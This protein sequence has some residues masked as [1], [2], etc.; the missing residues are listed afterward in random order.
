M[1]NTQTFS[2]GAPAVEVNMEY[3][4]LLGQQFQSLYSHTYKM[5]VLSSYVLKPFRVSKYGP[6][7]NPIFEVSEKAKLKPAY[8]AI[9]TS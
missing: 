1:T 6:Q 4:A 8:S 2:S 7:E 5:P 9:E 3:C